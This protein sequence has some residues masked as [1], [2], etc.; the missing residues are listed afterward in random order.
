MKGHYMTFRC[1]LCGKTFTN[2]GTGDEWT[3]RKAMANAALAASGIA[4]PT[5]LES[6]PLMHETHCCE[7]GSFGVADFLGMKY[8]E[9]RSPTA[10]CRN[11]TENESDSGIVL[12]G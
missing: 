2:G 8:R 3:A 11:D 7:D 12:R 9:E 5:K 10:R 1:R 6:Q 4:P